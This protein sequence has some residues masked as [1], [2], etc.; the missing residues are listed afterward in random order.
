MTMQRLM[1]RMRHITTLSRW[2]EGRRVLIRRVIGPPAT[3]VAIPGRRF[4]PAVT[5]VAPLQ[6]VR[7]SAARAAAEEEIED[8]GVDAF[9]T[10]V[11]LLAPP[12][13]VATESADAAL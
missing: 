3:T 5:P 10:S 4:L 12:E 9:D 8:D 6:L 13:R 1:P 11:H 7:D 2:A